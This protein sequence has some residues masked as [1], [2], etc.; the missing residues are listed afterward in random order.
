M[1]MAKEKLAFIG[2]PV[3]RYSDIIF[4]QI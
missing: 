2:T 1:K 3:L 4:A